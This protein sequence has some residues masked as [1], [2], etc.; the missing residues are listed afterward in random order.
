MKILLDIPE[1]KVTFLMDVLKDISYV[2]IKPLTDDKALLIEEA[3]EATD[4]IQL[5]RAGQKDANDAELF[6]NE[7]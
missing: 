6:L 1:K 3:K 7:L 5:I 2:R 4:E